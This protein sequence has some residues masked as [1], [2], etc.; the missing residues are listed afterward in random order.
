MIVIEVIQYGFAL[1]MIV[2]LTYHLIQSIT[3]LIKKRRV[4]SHT[5]KNRRFAIVVS[6]TKN[7]QMISQSLYSLFGLVY[8]RNR[9]DVIICGDC[10]SKE[11]TRIATKMGAVVV[12]GDNK[13]HDD[14]KCKLQQILEQIMTGSKTYDAIIGVESESL[15][16]GNYLDVIN[17]YFDRGSSVVQSNNLILP[18]TGTGRHDKQQVDLLFNNLFKPPGQIFFNSTMNSSGSNFCFS[19]RMLRE[20][21]DS[22]PAIYGDMEYRLLLQLNGIK[23]D[24]APE[25]VVWKQTPLKNGA[26]DLERNL[27]RENQYALVKRYFPKFLRT[28]IRHKSL[29]YFKSALALITPSAVSLLGFALLMVGVNIAGW[30]L[31]VESL[32]LI[33]VWLVAS[34]LAVTNIFTGGYAINTYFQAYKSI[35]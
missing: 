16:S 21:L 22:F 19:T 5:K 1:L 23:V 28:A 29:S 3:A 10:F 13:P 17:Y 31:G 18:Q 7:K 33:W 34:L 15:V 6:P 20:K 26:D 24:F 2:L 4:F 30:T 25:A 14:R 35:V 9:Y 27:S 32:N 11:A 12:N 8:P